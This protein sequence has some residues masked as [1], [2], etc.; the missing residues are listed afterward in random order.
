MIVQ[1]FVSGSDRVN[2]SELTPYFVLKTRVNPQFGRPP[3]ENHFG[4]I[5]SH[6][7]QAT[8][9]QELFFVTQCIC[10]FRMCA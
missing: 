8:S 10:P 4:K 2:N 9:E 5:L 3:L 6:C 7:V 1:M